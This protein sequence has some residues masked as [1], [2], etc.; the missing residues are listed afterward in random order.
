MLRE[1]AFSFS[2]ASELS[3][4]AV[5]DHPGPC[6]ISRAVEDDVGGNV[7]QKNQLFSAQPKF[8]CR[9][10]LSL[11]NEK[12]ASSTGTIVCAHLPATAWLH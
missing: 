10:I 3:A 8:Y 2:N 1:N 4:L 12:D 6:V 11:G 7:K 9:G 5:H